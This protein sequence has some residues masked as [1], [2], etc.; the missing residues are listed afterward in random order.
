MED[1]VSGACGRYGLWIARE[2]KAPQPLTQATLFCVRADVR[3]KP[4]RAV[5]PGDGC[6]SAGN[7]RRRVETRHI[8]R[9]Q[10]HAHQQRQNERASAGFRLPQPAEHD[11]ESSGIAR[12][13]Q[14][15]WTWR[16]HGLAQLGTPLGE[17]HFLRIDH[18]RYR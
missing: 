12:V 6:R 8:E 18:M 3:V 10:L 1:C 14:E 13:D 11:V 17:G 16:P 7:L 9:G 5:A 15:I 2:R 4:R